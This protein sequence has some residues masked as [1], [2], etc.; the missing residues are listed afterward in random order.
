MSFIL[1]CLKHLLLLIFGGAIVAFIPITGYWIFKEYQ[2]TFK[3]K[4]MN[5]KVLL[6]IYGLGVMVFGAIYFYNI[7]KNHSL[8]IQSK[9]LEEYI[10]TKKE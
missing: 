3:R 1:T 5:Y 7:Q 4:G 8:G 6:V 2:L 10:S 9:S